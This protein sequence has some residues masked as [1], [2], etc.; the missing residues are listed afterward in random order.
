MNSSAKNSNTSEKA[1]FYKSQGARKVI[2]LCLAGLWL[3]GFFFRYNQIEWKSFI[4]LACIVTLYLFEVL[5]SMTTSTK[6]SEVFKSFVFQTA[7]PIV[8]LTVV[9]I[10]ALAGKIEGASILSLFG[11]SLAY[12]TYVVGRRIKGEEVEGPED[13]TQ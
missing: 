6:T 11:L 1:P 4:A 9:C 10:M 7:V 5:Y 12:T 3:I 2:I 13:E 8:A